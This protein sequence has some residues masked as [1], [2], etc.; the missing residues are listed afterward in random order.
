MKKLMNNSVIVVVLLIASSFI[1]ACN[2][3]DK[4]EEGQLP[5]GEDSEGQI[6][7]NE[8]GQNHEN[9]RDAM[10][11][12]DW[13]S[14]KKE[15]EMRLKRNEEQIAALRTTDQRSKNYSDTQYDNMLSDLES[16]NKESQE[17]MENYTY[18]NDSDL[19]E[20]KKEFNQDLDNLEAAVT[21]LNVEDKD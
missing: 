15:S 21:N 14:Y 5:A 13:N 10:Q 16:K 12:D 19:T 18:S 6:M 3:A 9:M 11:T 1:M 20:F 17:K 7:M 2:F 8:E 4:K